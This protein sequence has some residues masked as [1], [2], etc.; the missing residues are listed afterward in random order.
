MGTYAPQSPLI[1][2]S[3]LNLSRIVSV[4]ETEG[5]DTTLLRARLSGSAHS[6]LKWAGWAI[7]LPPD[8]GHFNAPTSLL[9]S[10]RREEGPEPFSDTKSRSSRSP[11]TSGHTLSLQP[12][13]PRH[14]CLQWTPRHNSHKQSSYSAQPGRY[15]GRISESYSLL[16]P[17]T[18]MRLASHSR[19]GP[20]A[21]TARLPS[22]TVSVSGPE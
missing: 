4:I 18:C 14:P 3:R 9:K 8:S 6:R 20:S 2:Q 5:T 11:T 12:Y 21:H 19:R 7:I 15:V 17:F 10:H 22:N 1:P 16:P 13:R